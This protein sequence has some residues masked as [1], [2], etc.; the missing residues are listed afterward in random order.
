MLSNISN[1]SLYMF[2]ASIQFM[3]FLYSSW[4]SGAQL[5]IDVLYRKSCAH[6]SSCADLL[7]RGWGLYLPQFPP[8]MVS[9]PQTKCFW[10]WPLMTGE[11]VCARWSLIISHYSITATLWTLWWYSQQ[12]PHFPTWLAATFL[13]VRL[14]YPTPNYR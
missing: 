6:C 12:S 2:T 7:G 14:G 9:Q 13:L 1:L 4:A 5:N 8:M 3:V 11:L 10:H